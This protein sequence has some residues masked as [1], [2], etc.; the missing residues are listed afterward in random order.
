MDTIAN[1]MRQQPNG[2][3]FIGL[4]YDYDYY[5]WEYDWKW[6]DGSPLNFDNFAQSNPSEDYWTEDAVFMKS[7]FLTKT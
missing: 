2:D 1:I 4:N 6:T 5:S 3:Y 7:K